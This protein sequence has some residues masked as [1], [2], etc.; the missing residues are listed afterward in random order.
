MKINILGKEMHILDNLLC[1]VV[2]KKVFM[3]V[4]L[5]LRGFDKNI[6]LSFSINK[7]SGIITLTI[8]LNSAI[9]SYTC[10]PSSGKVSE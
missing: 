9:G 6:D 2:W 10:H 3:N 7:L 1:L 8:L 4:T 5:Q